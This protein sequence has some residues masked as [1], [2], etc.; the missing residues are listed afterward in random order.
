MPGSAAPTVPVVDLSPWFGTDAFARRRLIAE[1]DEVC[2]TVGFLQ[3]R[4]HGLSSS[5]T[6]EMLDVSG[7]LFDLPE[8][9]K[10]RWTP[11]HAV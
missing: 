5:L 4:G 7:Q 1:I 3:V 8:A 11:A 10:K 6:T 9:I 2:R